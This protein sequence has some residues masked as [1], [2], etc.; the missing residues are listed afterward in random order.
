MKLKYILCVILILIPL[1]LHGETRQVTIG[2]FNAPP[3][4]FIEDGKPQGFYI[5]LIKAISLDEGWELKFEIMSWS[6]GLQRMKE[7]SLDLW[8]STM[9]S[10]ERDEYLDY[11]G[12]GV[13]VTWVQVYTHTNS[14]IYDVFDLTN[15]TIGVM[16]KDHNAK[17]FKEYI[18][19]LEIVCNYKTYNDYPPLFEDLQNSDISAVVAASAPGDYY[20]L[21][22]NVR[23]TNIIL[24]PA[25]SFFVVSQG[26]NR[27]LIKP[28]H[29]HITRWKNDEE[30]FYYER[31]KYWFNREAN[32]RNVIPEYIRVGVAS[33]I[34]ILI[35]VTLLAIFLKKRI[36]LQSNELIHNEKF[37]Y[38]TNKLARVGGWR[39]S[40]D[41]KEF[42]WTKEMYYIYDVPFGQK[43]DFDRFLT[44]FHK[45]EKEKVYATFE[46]IKRTLLPAKF[47]LYFISNNQNKWIEVISS[48]DMQDNKMIGY[49]GATRDITELKASEKEK[50]RME[51]QLVQAQ[52]M[53]AIGTLAGGVAHDF[54]NILAAIFGYAE[55]AL[56]TKDTNKVNR[57]ISQ[58]L[59]AAERAKQLV[60]QILTF[61]RVGPDEKSVINPNVIIKEALK[62]IRASIP[63]TI[64]I[65]SNLEFNNN[66]YVNT[67]QL[68]QIVMNLCTNAYQAMLE[69]GGILDVR[70]DTINKEAATIHIPSLSLASGK[71]M[72][73]T[74]GD[75]GVGIPDEIKQ[76]I[77][78]PYFTTKQHKKGT[79]L[80]LSVVHGITQNHGGTVNVYSEAGHG[81]IFQVYLPICNKDKEPVMPD[82]EPIEYTNGN[83]TIMVV[84]DEIAITNLLKELL[85]RNGYTVYAYNDGIQAIDSFKKDAAKFDMIITDM[86]MPYM[87]GA[88]LSMK[89][90]LL[91]PNIDIILCTGHSEI[92]NKQSA[93]DIGIK[94]YLE[95]PLSNNKLLESIRRVLDKK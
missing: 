79:G 33:L 46:D 1:Q 53:E 95:K 51:E 13:L 64:Q 11:I 82:K 25:E 26:K 75:T 45:N 28:I 10:I 83:E 14:K 74:I 17:L 57:H 62:L 50:E 39:L 32:V 65:Q 76:K 92:I 16:K 15:K 21:S 34:I 80:G 63:T 87:T 66:I 67:T 52:K 22:Y 54:N 27:D 42:I 18:D 23:A 94:D 85:N 9:Y 88:E 49:T 77:F 47:D 3:L 91:N 90:M 37:L 86:T 59:I 68:H 12:D 19:K 56:T 35:I 6:N 43:M 29:K 30:S 73:L 81:T 70:L 60:K 93:M 5:D 38:A 55:L 31:M 40:K 78:E 58:V 71:Y 72:K 7:G 20:S 84:D 69:H 61:G 2:V 48:A 8:T 36:K 24:N 41:F 89:A 44:Q 4:V